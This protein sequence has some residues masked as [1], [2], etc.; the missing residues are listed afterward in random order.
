MNK[1]LESVAKVG[2]YPADYVEWFN[3]SRVAIDEIIAERERQP[4]PTDF[5]GG[6]VA[7][8][9]SGDEPI[10]NDEIAAQVFAICAAALTTTTTETAVTL[11]CWMTHRD[12][13]EILR[14]R[15]ELMP[16][17]IEEALRLHPAGLFIFPR[18]VTEDTEVGGTALFEGMP[19]HV[20]VAAAD[21]D[22]VAYPDPLEFKIDRDPEARDGLRRRISFLRRRDPRAEGDRHQLADVHDEA[23]EHGLRRSEL[24]ATLRRSDG[25]DCAPGDARQLELRQ[26]SRQPDAPSALPERDRALASPVALLRSQSSPVVPSGERRS[27]WPRGR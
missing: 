2:G 14:E 27:G 3:A 21:L 23:P 12:E 15:P 20:C 25:R 7:G 4:S 10:T 6:L 9:E 8:R 19:L 22:P 17:A 11:W 1:E 26:T 5:I 18:F 16:Q 24:A 13:F